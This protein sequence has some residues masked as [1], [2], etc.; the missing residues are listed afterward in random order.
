MGGSGYFDLVYY[1]DNGSWLMP[2]NIN[3]AIHFNIS[4]PETAISATR[5]PAPL[6]RAITRRISPSSTI[7]FISIFWSSTGTITHIRDHVTRSPILHQPIFTI[8]TRAMTGR[9]ITVL[10][11]YCL[12][13][14]IKNRS[15]PG[16]MIKFGSGCRFSGLLSLP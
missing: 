15:G 2:D 7:P 6:W 3:D 9:V 14:N 5:K 10:L 16:N 12:S 13:V 1:I 11:M 8:M 4:D